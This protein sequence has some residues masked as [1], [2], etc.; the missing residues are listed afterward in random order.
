MSQL[1]PFFIMGHPRSGTTLLRAILS[2]HA[3]V[4]I[5]PENGTLGPMLR[6][7]IAHRR[8]AWPVVASAVI[9]KFC[10]GYEFQ[11]WQLD[12]DPLRKNAEALPSTEQSLAGLIHL[13]YR[14][15]GIQHAPGK[16]RWGDKTVPGNTAYAEKIDLVFPQARFVHLY[17]DGRDCITSA[18]KAGFFGRDY[19]R[20]AYMWKDHMR[21]ACYFGNRILPQNRFFEISYEELVLQ[22]EKSLTNLCHFLNLEPSAD[23]LHYDGTVHMTDVKSIGHHTNVNK[24]IFQSSIGN[25]RHQLPK[26]ERRTILKIIE[27]ELSLFGYG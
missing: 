27:K 3:A 20:A 21:Q 22:P 13:I 25:W 9:D 10:Q 8:H 18:V 6:T 17:R 2:Q 7:F 19:I 1:A 26:S 12:L 24:P 23:M 16:D 11:H 4:F 15:Y 5:P 14:T